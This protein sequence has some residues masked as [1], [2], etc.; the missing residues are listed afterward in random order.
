VNPFVGILV[1][2]YN[3][4]P[5]ILN[6]LLKSVYDQE[7]PNLIMVCVDDGSDVPVVEA[8]NFGYSKERLTI[9]RIPHSE[10]AVARS[11][12]IEVLKQTGCEYLMFVDSDMVL[13]K[14]FIPE[15]VNFAS[16][17][18]AD[19][20]VIPEHSFS[21]YRNLWTRI[22][23]F[24]RNLYQAGRTLNQSSVEAAR[25]WQMR[26]FPGFDKNMT[27]FEEI[28]P[29][30]TCL[31]KR[32][33]ILKGSSF[34]LH[35]EKHVTYQS[36]FRKKS[37]YFYE[38]SGNSMDRITDMIKRFYLFRTQLYHP[39]NLLKYLKH[40]IKASMVFIMYLLLTISAVHAMFLRKRGDHL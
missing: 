17:H 20:Y 5:E 37:S 12:G 25:F 36:L 4:N 35:D 21:E 30:L 8:I 29:T 7:Y 14:G 11:A 2:A 1:T 16:N 40:P 22:K 27:A 15:T 34:L 39:D 6:R 9:I 18:P 23:V 19:G 33:K 24:E 32:G 10:R 28:Q 38:M 3:D 26:S 13:P 31:K